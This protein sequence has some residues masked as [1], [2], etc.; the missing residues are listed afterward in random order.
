MKVKILEKKK[1][2]RWQVSNVSCYMSPA[3]IKGVKENLPQ[4]EVTFDKFHILKIRHYTF[5]QIYK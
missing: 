5:N 4:L 2:M 3:F 1:G